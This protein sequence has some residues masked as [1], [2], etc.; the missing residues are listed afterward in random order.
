MPRSLT[1]HTFTEKK[2]AHGQEIFLF[3]TSSFY[4]AIEP[5]FA[6]VEYS[7]FEVDENGDDTG[8]QILFDPEDPAPPENCR[9]EVLL[10]PQITHS[11]GDLWCPASDVDGLFG[12]E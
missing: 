1:L 7:W 5:L 11:E 12:G 6:E 8:D 3:R 4:G 2:P 10:T 9:L